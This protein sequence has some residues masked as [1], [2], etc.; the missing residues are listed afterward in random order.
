MT[1]ETRFD[2]LIDALSSNDEPTDEP[3]KASKKADKQK[4]KHKDPNYKQVGIY[5]P[6]DLHRRMKIASAATDVETSE[7]AA[8]GIELWLAANTSDI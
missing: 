4:P 7:I 8:A 6:T 2:S 5:L 1:E 3:A